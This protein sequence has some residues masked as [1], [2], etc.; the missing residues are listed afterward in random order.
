MNEAMILSSEE[1]IAAER[2][3][4]A[5]LDSENDWADRDEDDE[6]LEVRAAR[7]LCRRIIEA[8]EP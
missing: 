7:A 5:Y 6:A 8:C 4:R 3:A 2:I 1:W